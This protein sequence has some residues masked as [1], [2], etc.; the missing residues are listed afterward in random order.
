[1]E[2]RTI[3]WDRYGATALWSVHART[4]AGSTCSEPSRAWTGRNRR[5]LGRGHRLQ[6]VGGL[7]RRTGLRDQEV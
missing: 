3:A 2:F 4:C 6:R 5:L 7:R 1:M